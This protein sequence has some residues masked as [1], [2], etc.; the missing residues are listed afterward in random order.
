MDFIINLYF[1]NV[2]INNIYFPTYLLSGSHLYILG[3]LIPV[4]LFYTQTFNFF[5]SEFEISK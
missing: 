1:P 4:Y 2:V 3:L 5:L